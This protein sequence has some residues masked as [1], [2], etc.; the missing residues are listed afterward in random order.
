MSD[1]VSQ[2]EFLCPADQLV[3]D[4][5]IE[6][7]TRLDDQPCW[8]VATRRPDGPRAWLNVCPHA[9]R[10]LNW[11]PNQFIRDDQGQLVCAAHGAVFETDGGQCVA[12][13]CQG[14]SL[15]AVEVI[16]EDGQILRRVNG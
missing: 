10:P 12:G 16:E 11:A 9:G 15:K 2:F 3:V 14:A 13:P 7:E 5:F 4:Q 8:L 6:L 1:P